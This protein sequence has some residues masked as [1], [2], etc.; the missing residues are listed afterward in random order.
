M[1]KNKEIKF[2]IIAGRK[3]EHIDDLVSEIEKNNHSAKHINIKDL[4][5]V[6]TGEEMAINWKDKNILDFDIFILRNAFRS[7]KNEMCIVANYLL[8]NK[9][10]IIDE[11]IGQNYI[12]GKVY[13]SYLLTQAG[14]PVPKIIQVLQDDGSVDV[15]KIAEKLGFPM[16][17]KPIVGSK[18]RG[19]QKISNLEELKKVEV[20]DGADKYFFQEYI[21]IENDIRVFVVGEKVLGAMK[22]YVSKDDFRSNASLGA[23]VEKLDASKE[24]ADLAV[25]ATKAYGYEVAGV[26]IVEY[27]E[28]KYVLEVNNAPQWLA[29][30]SVTGINPAGDIIKYLID[31]YYRLNNYEK[32]E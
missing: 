9:K 29:F 14:I 13:E 26:D 6:N 2:A 27:K 12:A 30:K 18:G 4:V 1:T 19:I 5:F 7:L 21:P 22:R 17:V 20:I 31:K 25:R 32:N 15:E 3:G 10:T 11:V 8:K 23:E 28:K 16:I 24:L